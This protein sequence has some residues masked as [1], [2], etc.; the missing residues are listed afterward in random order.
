MRDSHL[1]YQAYFCWLIINDF[2]ASQEDLTPIPGFW[3][4]K[5]KLYYYCFTTLPQT[6]F[7]GLGHKKFYIWH[8]SYK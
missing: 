6:L 3:K 2:L 8:A 5:T 4:T 7:Y 1:Y